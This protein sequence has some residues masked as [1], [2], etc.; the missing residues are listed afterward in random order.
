MLQLRGLDLKAAGVPAIEQR[1]LATGLACLTGRGCNNR[2]TAEL[3][4]EGGTNGYYVPGS[5]RVSA[6]AQCCLHHPL[7]DG[8][9]AVL[10]Q[11]DPADRR[12]RSVTLRCAPATGTVLALLEAD[13]A[14]DGL[15]ERW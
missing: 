9:L 4:V 13:G 11:L 5:R 7:I 12:L 2:I 15:A 14:L 10:P 8:A 3:H 6:I 1:E